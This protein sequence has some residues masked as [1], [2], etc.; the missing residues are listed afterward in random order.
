V[1]AHD[2]LLNARGPLELAPH[3]VIQIGEVD[4]TVEQTSTITSAHAEATGVIEDVTIWASTSFG[5]DPDY[6]GTVTIDRISVEVESDA[7]TS[8]ATT[9][10]HWRVDDLRVWDPDLVVEGDDDDDEDEIGGYLGPWTFGFDHDCGGWVGLPQPAPGDPRCGNFTNPNPVVIPVAYQGVDANG[11][12]GTSLVIVAGATVQ[13]AEA[14]ASQGVSSASAGQQNVLS[15][16][17]RDDIAGAVDL[18]PMLAG[19]GAA[20][21]SV[22]YVSHSH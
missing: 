18:E 8:A 2:F 13:D 12:P 7:S 3:A 19:L 15:I 20:D 10:V 9:H 22:S 5:S 4:G 17:T 6:E 16:S 21:S 1:A 14:D 11:D